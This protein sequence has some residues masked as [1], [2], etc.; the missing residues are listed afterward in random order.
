[1][2][3]FGMLINTIIL[4]HCAIVIYMD[5]IPT[6]NVTDEIQYY[7]VYVLFRVHNLS[8]IYKSVKICHA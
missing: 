4:I 8:M 6:L 7:I 3:I 1:M 2:Y 5:I